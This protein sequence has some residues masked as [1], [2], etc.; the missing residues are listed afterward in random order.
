[1]N[2]EH[3]SRK[4][5][6]GVALRVGEVTANGDL[7]TEDSVR[8]ALAKF[9]GMP[10]KDADGN[11]IGEVKRALLCDGAVTIEAEEE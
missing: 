1:M 11:V 3:G 9:R 10:V 5:I 6:V 4:R 2:S 8:E 7:Y